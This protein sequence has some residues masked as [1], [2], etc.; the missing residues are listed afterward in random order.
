MQKLYAHLH[1]A[2]GCT[3]IIELPIA[4]S[5]PPV[6]WLPYTRPSRAGEQLDLL[7]DVWDGTVSCRREFRYE[8]RESLSENVV[9][10]KYEEVVA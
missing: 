2:C 7:V 9:V 10:F 6:Y 5:P 3:R 4:Q 8:G 1:T